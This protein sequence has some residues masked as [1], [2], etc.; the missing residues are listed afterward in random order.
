MASYKLKILEIRNS[1]AHI[2][3]SG[4]LIVDGYAELYEQ[5]KFGL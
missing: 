3:C 5:E 1:K 4:I 2:Q